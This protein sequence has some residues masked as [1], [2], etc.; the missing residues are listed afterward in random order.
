V[1]RL[2][3]PQRDDALLR[4]HNIRTVRAVPDIEQH[5]GKLVELRRGE[6]RPWSVVGR[7]RGQPEPAGRVGARPADDTA[8]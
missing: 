1:D 2:V 4:A 5:H 6:R 3:I 7:F 8:Q